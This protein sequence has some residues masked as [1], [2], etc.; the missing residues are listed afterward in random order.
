MSEAHAGSCLCGAVR[1]VASGPLKAVS[2]CHCSMC[3]KAHGA[4]FASYG[5]ARVEDFRWEQGEDSLTRYQSSATVQRL[6]CRH[7]GSNLAWVS[8]ENP[9]W[10]ALALGTLDTDFQPAKQKHIHVASKACWF[11]ITDDWPQRPG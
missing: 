3:R 10:I 6:F 2:H 8:R 1:C 9:E 5:A 11:A 4:A 7:C